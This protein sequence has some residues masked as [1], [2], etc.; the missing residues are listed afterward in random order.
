MFLPMPNHVNPDD[1]KRQKIIA[2]NGRA[3]T[4]LFLLE[5][6]SMPG[7]LQSKR[8]TYGLGS[9]GLNVT[10]GSNRRLHRA[11]LT[12]FLTGELA[13]SSCVSPALCHS[14][15]QCLFQHR[16]WSDSYRASVRVCLLPGT[17]PRRPSVI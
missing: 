8:R 6:G 17:L 2:A 12:S 1:Y 3:V 7:S 13:G 16:R 9:C 15:H 4:Q 11:I 10:D 5:F 14:Q